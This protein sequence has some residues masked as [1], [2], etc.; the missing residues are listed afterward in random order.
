MLLNM[1]VRE[2]SEDFGAGCRAIALARGMIDQSITGTQA[3]AHLLD[4][5]RLRGDGVEAGLQ[6]GGKGGGRSDEELSD[7][8][9]S[10]LWGDG[11]ETGM[12]AAMGGVGGA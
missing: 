4:V 2:D 10:T 12:H 11:V 6:P 3:L 5:E 8:E 9:G 1:R 7:R